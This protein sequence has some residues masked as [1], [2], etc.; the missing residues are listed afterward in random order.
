MAHHG[1]NND[2]SCGVGKSTYKEYDLNQTFVH[3][4]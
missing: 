2:K 1:R 3:L 4:E